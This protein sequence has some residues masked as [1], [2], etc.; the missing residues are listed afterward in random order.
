MLAN[1]DPLFRYARALSR[2]PADAEELVQECYRRALSAGKKPD[3]K[4]SEDVRRWLFV[5]LR[6]VWK[7]EVRRRGNQELSELI[8]Q[9]PRSEGP[10]PEAQLLRQALQYEIRAALDSLSAPHREIVVLR[11][12]EGLSYEQISSVIDCPVGTVMSR[13]AR[14]RGQLR[15]VLAEVSGRE[16]PAKNADRKVRS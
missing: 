11:D 12:V 10:T 1:H 4:K 9:E 2:D 8:D 16:V 6:N 5:I 15:N 3:P 7:N 14:A 13:L